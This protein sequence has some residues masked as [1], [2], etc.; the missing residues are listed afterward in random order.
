[1]VLK[2]H[3]AGLSVSS[4]S[5][6]QVAVRGDVARAYSMSGC[7]GD[8][9]LDYPATPLRHRAPCWRGRQPGPGQRAASFRRPYRKPPARSRPPSAASSRARRTKGAVAEDVTVDEFFL[10]V[11]G[12]A[13]ATATGRGTRDAG[14][15]DRDHLQRACSSPVSPGRKQPAAGIWAPIS[16]RVPWPVKAGS[17]GGRLV[18]GSRPDLLLRAAVGQACPGRGGPGGVDRGT[19]RLPP[20]RR[21]RLG[22]RAGC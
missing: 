4:R 17:G 18:A 1:M 19:G 8:W 2:R 10:L 12:L 22:A 16:G 14:P 3:G 21:W 20:R 15:R 6:V 13:Q 9:R 5:A 11:R 7:F